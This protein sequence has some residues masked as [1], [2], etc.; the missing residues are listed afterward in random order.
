MRKW[1]IVM[2]LLY[3]STHNT[4]RVIIHC[5]VWS[6]LRF[7]LSVIFLKHQIRT[8]FMQPT[9]RPYSINRVGLRMSRMPPL[10][11]LCNAR[12]NIFI[13]D[14]VPNNSN[15]LLIISHT[16]VTYCQSI[17]LCCKFYRFP[18]NKNS[19]VEH[20]NHYADMLFLTVCVLQ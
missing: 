17:N 7:D 13:P 2:V 9:S 4:L 14:P 19:S 12:V 3:F 20:G 15:E 1:N 16:G 6:Y 18:P 11:S 8:R 10:S 5:T